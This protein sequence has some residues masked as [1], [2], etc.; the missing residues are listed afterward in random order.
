MSIP[1]GVTAHAVSPDAPAAADIITEKA[2]VVIQ[3]RPVV[4]ATTWL[5]D[6]IRTAVEVERELQ[7][8]TPPGTRLTLPT[9]T[10]LDRMPTRWVVRDVHCGYYDGL[11]GAVLHWHEGHF[12][13]LLDNNGKPQ[14]ADAYR[15]QPDGNSH[16]QL[17]LA[18]SVYE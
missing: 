17:L 18:D 7:I 12:T 4:A 8:V 2:I 6:I 15:P 16:R 5:T 13:P 10:L 11:T 9:R 1:D 3:D 14:L